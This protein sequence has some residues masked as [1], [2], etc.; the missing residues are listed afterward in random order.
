MTENVF[1]KAWVEKGRTHKVDLKWMGQSFNDV[2]VKMYE[3]IKKDFVVNF[4]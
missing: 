3:V 4:F 1:K 2:D